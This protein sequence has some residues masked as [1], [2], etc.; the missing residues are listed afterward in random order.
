M[1]GMNQ[2]RVAMKIVEIKTKISTRRPRSR[3]L[4]D[5]E[6]VL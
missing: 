3:R 2:T 6:N 5:V 4:E 1:I